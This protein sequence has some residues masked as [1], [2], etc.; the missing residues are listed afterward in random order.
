[1]PENT[2]VLPEKPISFKPN[3]PKIIE[4]LVW[5]AQRHPGLSTYYFVKI[6]YLAEK[7]HL[8][9]YGR[10][11]W[12]DTYI[13]MK[14]GPVPSVAYDMLK[15]NFSFNLAELKSIF[16]KALVVS[17]DGG[18]PEFS[19]KRTPILD[20]FSS[21]DVECLE[22]AYNKFS[23]MTLR[24][25]MDYTHDEPEYREAEMNGVMQYELMIDDGTQRSKELIEYLRSYGPYLA[26]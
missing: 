23:P 1:M 5:I 26:L 8:Q 4:G 10:P 15:R 25:I 13:K 17:E 6:M 11:I 16:N 2:R 19:A 12:G 14:L 20:D 7:L 9:K 24:Q 18:Y 3:K 21:S 22:M